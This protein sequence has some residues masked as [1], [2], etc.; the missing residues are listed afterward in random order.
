MSSMETVQEFHS[1]KMELIENEVTGLKKRV[2]SLEIKDRDI[3]GDLGK[4]D[5]KVADLGISI[6][7]LA[8]PKVYLELT[9]KSFD[10]S[11]FSIIKLLLIRLDH[12]EVK[13]YQRAVAILNSLVIRTTDCTRSK[14]ICQI[15]KDLKLRP[16]IAIFN[17]LLIQKVR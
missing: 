8:S 3:L 16:F 9:Y 12:W 14:S 13:G 17:R 11:I 10:N 15:I 6:S 2:D 7:S 1:A 5:R 4:L